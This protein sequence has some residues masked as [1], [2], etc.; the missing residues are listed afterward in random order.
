MKKANASG[1][2]LNRSSVRT[3][4]SRQNNQS[5]FFIRCG[6]R[7][8]AQ[9]KSNRIPTQ[10]YRGDDLVVFMLSDRGELSRKIIK[11]VFN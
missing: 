8:Y 9:H 2:L 5:D 6:K 10:T 11:I 1:K 3:G 7:L 4:T